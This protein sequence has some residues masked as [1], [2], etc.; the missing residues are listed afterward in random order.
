M[1]KEKNWLE[2]S[3]EY[4]LD[5]AI[6]HD[7]KAN[8]GAILGRLFAEGLKKEQIKEV[9]PVINE[10]IKK[11]NSMKLEAQVKEFEQFKQKF[12]KLQKEKEEKSEKKD[13]PDIEFKG[14]IIT[15]LAPEPSKYNHYGHAM[16]FL[17]NYLYS[18]KYKGK[19]KMR[20]EDTNPEKVSQEYV[21]A[22]KEDLLEYL[23]IKIEGKIRYVS[24]D[25]P[26]MYRHAETLIKNK[27]AYMCF[28]SRDKL[29]DLREKGL[30][31]S[32]RQQEVKKNLSEWKSFLKGKYMKGQASLRLKGNMGSSNYVMRDPVI[33]R[34]VPQEHFR[35]KK[36]YKIWPM[37]DFYNPIED[38]LMGITHI[39]R[40]NEFDMRVELQNYIKKLLKLKTQ[41]ITQYGRINI[42][43][44]KSQGREIRELVESGKYTGW[45][46]PRLPTLKALKRRGILKETLYQLAKTVGFS[47]YQVNMNFDMI[48]AINR[49]LIDQ[50]A[51]RFF[52]IESPVK[53]EI[54]NKP[55][56]QEVDVRV[57]PDSEETRRIKIGNDLYIANKDFLENKDREVRLMHLF[58]V[59]LKKKVF[60]SEENKEIPRLQWVSDFVK[61]RIFMDNAE[62]KEGIAESEIKKVKIG[63]IIQFERF[64]FCKLDKKNESGEFEFWFSHY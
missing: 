56:I 2:L 51:R 10:Q 39:F 30:E 37:Y 47:K 18:V 14:K 22:M 7:G 5:N 21:D 23:G 63:D 17:I 12:L 61:V 19:C 64:G 33:F 45:D 16:S 36:K 13:L 34:A 59:D 35:H 43:G 31:C 27:N 6:S 9:M 20:F 25:M 29:K 42:E 60:T 26:K 41:V 1:S 28:C 53:L 8:S 3:Y 48:A 11:V 57:H 40:T 32:C 4:A 49:K 24:D 52:F 62:W 44:S 58:N 50:T 38:S 15:R 55:P 54:K 46:D